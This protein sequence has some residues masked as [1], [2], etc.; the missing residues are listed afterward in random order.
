MVLEVKVLPKNG[1]G[2][3]GPQ[4]GPGPLGTMSL[5]GLFE[6]ELETIPRTSDDQ[7]VW[8]SESVAWRVGTPT[9]DHDRDASTTRDASTGTLDEAVM[10]ACR[11]SRWSLVST[12]ST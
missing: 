5:F 2:F 9:P 7:A 8:C 12:T 4:D 1:L 3:K 6:C 10:M 11:P